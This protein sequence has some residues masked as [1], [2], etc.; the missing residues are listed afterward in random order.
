M[1]QFFKRVNRSKEIKENLL[2]HSRTLPRKK[3]KKFKKEIEDIIDAWF[4]ITSF[5]EDIGWK[6]VQIKSLRDTQESILNNYQKST[7][8]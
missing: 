4:L 5:A 6:S 8:A 3:K 1:E 7:N 2:K